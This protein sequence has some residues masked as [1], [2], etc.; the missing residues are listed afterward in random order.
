[1]FLVRFSIKKPCGTY[2]FMAILNNKTKTR[3]KYKNN[4]VTKSSAQMYL[5]FF[6]NDFSI[7]QKTQK[8]ESKETRFRLLK[9]LVNQ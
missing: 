7:Y 6:L 5:Y 4:K 9:F 2:Y 8:Y 3:K 1:M